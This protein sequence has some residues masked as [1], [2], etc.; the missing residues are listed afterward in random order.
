MSQENLE[1]SLQSLKQKHDE[2]WANYKNY[3]YQEYEPRFYRQKVG[4]KLEF[5]NGW[6]SI[7]ERVQAEKKVNVLYLIWDKLAKWYW[8]IT[9]E[10]LFVPRMYIQK[11]TP[12]GP[13]W[14]KESPQ[15]AVSYE[16]ALHTPL[17]QRPS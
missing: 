6:K 8:E 16:T 17:S 4:R 13:R 5:T 10:H 1:T 7:E 15:E 9:G 14:V 12:D 3:L 11:E 2:A